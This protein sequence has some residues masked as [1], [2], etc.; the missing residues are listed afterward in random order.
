MGSRTGV[1]GLAVALATAGGILILSAIRN[2]GITDAIRDIMGKR[3]IG[4]SGKKTGPS[5]KDVQTVL[6]TAASTPISGA[7]AGALSAAIAYRIVETARAQIGKPYIFG[8][9]GP[10]AF[11]CSG[12]VTYCLKAAGVDDKRRFTQDYLVWTGAT[13]VPRDQ[14]R[15]GDLVCWTGHIGIATSNSSMIHAPTA[16]DVVK[17]AKIWDAPV[18]PVIRRIKGGTGG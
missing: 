7:A 15:S 18:A 11:D 6:D 12:L 14:C 9:A 3:P 16:G 17:E 13:T 4:T 1:S 5:I 2:Q 8:A 10:D